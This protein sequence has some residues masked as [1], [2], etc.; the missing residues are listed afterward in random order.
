MVSTCFRAT[1]IKQQVLYWAIFRD[2]ES[3]PIANLRIADILGK[4]NAERYRVQVA[5]DGLV[6]RAIRRGDIRKDI[7]ADLLRALIGVSHVNGET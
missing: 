7:D 1:E 3:V 6:K 2:L 4:M 5:V